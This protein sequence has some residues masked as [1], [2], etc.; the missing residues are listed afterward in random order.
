MSVQWKYCIGTCQILHFQR[1]FKGFSF[2]WIRMWVKLSSIGILQGVRK[3]QKG[4]VSPFFGGFPAIFSI[5]ELPPALTFC[6]SNSRCLVEA[7]TNTSTSSTSDSGLGYT[8]YNI[9]HFYKNSIN[10]GVTA[11][12]D[13][14]ITMFRMF[15]KTIEFILRHILLHWLL[16][17][18]PQNV[19]KGKNGHTQ[20]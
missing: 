19:A 10:I 5:I 14:L 18:G 9:H 3:S 1:Q 17:E 15:Q 7:A 20:V 12:K 2:L 8:V 6:L 11:N 13:I 16:T 4:L